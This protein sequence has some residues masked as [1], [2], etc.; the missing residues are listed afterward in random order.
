MTFKEIFGKTKTFCAENKSDILTFGVIFG[1]WATAT[2]FF[3]AGP[4]VKKAK[5]DAEMELKYAKRG[6]EEARKAIIVKKYKTMIKIIIVPVS[7]GVVTTL[8]ELA[9]HKENKANKEKILELSTAYAMT[10]HAYQEYKQHVNASVSKKKAKDIQESILKDHVE[11]RKEETKS[12]KEAENIEDTGYG[13]VKC[14]DEQSGRTFYSS[15]NAIENAILKCS[16]MVQQEMYVPMN[17]FYYENNLKPCGFGEK[18][19]FDVSSLENGRIPVY[20]AAI[21]DE[22]NMPILEV[23]SDPVF[24]E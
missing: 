24:L 21:L 3:K 22:N 16:F 15:P 23:R 6:D 5:E 13:N 11:A 20:Y 17:D 7:F 10:N 19:G 4:K 9:N 1:V 2:A 12:K 14:Y 18:Y 8:L